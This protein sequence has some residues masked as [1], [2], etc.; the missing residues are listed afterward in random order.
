MKGLSNKV[1]IITGSATSIGAEV[2]RA[3]VEAG[4]RVIIADIAE[5]AGA[6]LA[7]DLG[8]A[9]RF[10][11][12]NV[13]NDADLKAAVETAVET[14]G[15]LDF[16]VNTACTYLDN[17][18]DSTRE[19]FLEALNINAAGGFMLVQ[20]ARPHL[21]ASK[22]AVVNFGSISAKVAQPGRCLYPMSKGAIHQ[23]T[24]NEALL[25]AEDG[26]RVNTVSPGWTWCTIMDQVTDG[27]RAKTDQVAA[28][29]HMTGRVGDQREVADAVLFLCS[30]HASFI[31]G[32]DLPVDGGYTALGPEQQTDALSKLAE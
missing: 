23:L 27:N 4:T 16:V 1:A 29:F 12:T 13:M 10:V 8:E 5:E 9:V 24:R 17:G 3:F 22:G 7:S 28:P 31:T 32:T 20:Y 14:W 30:D 2:A 26:I 19:E 15:Q 18:M 11:R 6:A 21:K 25:L